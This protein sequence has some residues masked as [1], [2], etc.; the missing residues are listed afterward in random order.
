ML[1]PNDDLMT[2]GEMVTSEFRWRR[3]W[4][5]SPLFGALS[6]EAL[7]VAQAAPFVHVAEDAVSA[8]SYPLGPSL[9]AWLGFQ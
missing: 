3:S 7:D 1:A 4:C 9:E 2:L 5:G 6:E 8:E